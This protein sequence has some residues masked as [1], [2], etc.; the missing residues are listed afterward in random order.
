MNV[1][2]R[3]DNS[4]STQLRG[5]QEKAVVVAIREALPE[6]RNML[7]LPTGSGKSLIIAEIVERLPDHQ[8]LIITPRRSLLKQLQKRLR[9][10][11]VLSSTLGNDL[12][13]LHKLVIGTIQTVM[14]RVIVPPDLIIVDENHVGN[15]DGAYG[16]LIR[17]HPNAAVIG[18][19]AT[20]YRQNEPINAF[21]IDWKL[22]YSISI[23]ELIEGRFLVPPRSMAISAAT[24]DVD[25]NAFAALGNQTVA[26]VTDRIVPKLVEAVRRERRKKCLVFCIDI[27]H[28]ELTSDLLKHRGEGHVYVIHSG[29]SRRI[30]DKMIRKF[31]Q[32]DQRAWLV[33]VGL[34]SFGVDIPAIDCIAILRD[35]GSF[36][37]L[38]QIIGRGL[39]IFTGK[40]DC[41]I[42]DFGGGTRKF[43]FID[44]P[45]MPQAGEGF[46]PPGEKC[47]PAC[48]QL[49][50]LSALKCGGCGQMF[51]RST[52][53][54]DSA[55][56]N[57]LLASG[58][59][60]ATYLGAS[61][62]QDDRGVWQVEHQMSL[63]QEVL[64]AR[65]DSLAKPDMARNP[66]KRGDDMVVRRVRGDL[67]Q[68][69]RA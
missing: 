64:L 53:L 7:V 12:G 68:I 46:G 22:V 20:P 43:G 26:E 11:G 16:D 2:K 10:H 13:N 66:H 47:C 38:V 35:I 25:G 31:E 3:N 5:Y 30:Q 34:V 15:P 60:R 29:Q 40:L 65:S 8:I 14:N 9:A 27:K 33:N 51:P 32:S 63:G 56:S 17:R 48:C 67:V 37:L 61:A 57:Q 41:L 49:N 36:A 45:R 54:K 52:S 39:R 58:L 18:L 59:L 44:E 69:L 19:T 50:H 21:G 42:Y 55:T 62:T 28:A 6:S 4:R 1:L 24:A 23:S